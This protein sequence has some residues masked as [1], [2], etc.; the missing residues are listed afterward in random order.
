MQGELD[1]TLILTFSE[2]GRRIKENGSKGT[3]HGTA[4][5]VFVMGGTSTGGVFNEPVD[6]SRE[7]NNDLIHSVDF[8]QVYATVL[9]N[10]F[11]ADPSKILGGNYVPMDFIS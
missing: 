6:L 1:N 9:N 5:N 7:L 2:F 8:R 4:N 3:D 11:R 10:W